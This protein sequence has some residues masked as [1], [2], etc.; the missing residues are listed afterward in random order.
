[1]TAVAVVVIVAVVV[2]DVAVHISAKR[3]KMISKSLRKQRQRHL[4]AFCFNI[5]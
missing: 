2:D 1:M 5:N 4:Y 3:S